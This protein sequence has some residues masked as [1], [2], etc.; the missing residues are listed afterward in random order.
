MLT[1]VNVAR[2][3]NDYIR[4]LPWTR[5]S[6][7]G[8][9]AVFDSF[10]I[11]AIGTGFLMK[12]RVSEGEEPDLFIL[13]GSEGRIGE[14]S[15]RNKNDVEVCFKAYVLPAITREYYCDVAR[16]LINA[17]SKEIRASGK[18]ISQEQWVVSARGREYGHSIAFGDIK[19]VFSQDGDEMMPILEYG[20]NGIVT[21]YNPVSL[22]EDFE[23]I[24]ETLISKTKQYIES[25]N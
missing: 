4:E 22:S 13:N 14:V 12:L 23:S 16:N 10:D 19:V 15:L 9:Q 1:K 5:D 6:I 25:I 21:K 24:K 11:Y 3:L 17:I 7:F 20:L 8:L 2:L 18:N